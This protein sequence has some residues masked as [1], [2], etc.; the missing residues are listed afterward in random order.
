M[1]SKA[2]ENLQAALQQAMEIRERLGGF[3]YLAET[4]ARR[5]LRA[6]FGRSPRVR[7]CILPLTGQS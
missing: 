2:I 3:P 5:V 4:Y 1:D 7:V 6:T